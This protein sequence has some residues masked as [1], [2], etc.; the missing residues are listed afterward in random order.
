MSRNRLAPPFISF[1]LTGLLLGLP[2]P[3]TAERFTLSA[4]GTEVTDAK[5]GLIWRRCPEGTTWNKQTCRGNVDHFTWYEWLQ[6][7]NT[8]VQLTGK[9]W[10]LPNIKELN[11]LF[12]YNH[13]DVAYDPNVFPATPNTQFWSSTPYALDAFYAWVVNTFDGAVYYSYLEDFGA[14]R[15]VRD[16]D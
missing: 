16:P 12:D 13:I 1:M 10:R 3:A 5:T 15:L 6:L 8:Q 2:S 9:A 7:T 11:S 14:A 4:D